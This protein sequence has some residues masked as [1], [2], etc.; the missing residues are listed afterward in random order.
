MAFY[1]SASTTV[2]SQRTMV[3]KFNVDGVTGKMGVGTTAP[4]AA[5]QIHAVTLDTA[6]SAITN[7]LTLD[8]DITGTP[9]IGAGVGINALIDSTSTA[10]QQAGTVSWVWTNATTATLASKF[11]VQTR[12]GGSAVADNL[13]LDGSGNLSVTGTNTATQFKLSALNT[14]PSSASDTGTLGEVRIT[15]TYIYVC[16]ATNTWVRA[17]LAT[18]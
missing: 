1:Y 4:T 5:T 7:I 6:T 15:A 16:T 17:A 10:S 18:W 3:E 12:T 14:A 9:A 11:V 8:H 13:V 2:G